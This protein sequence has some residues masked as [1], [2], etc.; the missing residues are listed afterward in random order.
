MSSDI[1]KILED[2]VMVKCPSCDIDLAAPLNYFGKVLC[3][4]CKE[5]FPVNSEDNLE[6][7]INDGAF[8]KGF[9]APLWPT[10]I[11][12]LLAMTGI[13]SS[14]SS[15]D[16]TGL[17]WFMCSLILWPIIGFSIAKNRGIFVKSFREGARNSAI[18]AIIVGGLIWLWF[19]SFIAGGVTN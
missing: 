17:I 5:K 3:P 9:F 7:E 14:N 15:P 16:L 12:V 10:I 2:K 19:L 6:I 13:L 1:S 4:A 8:W 18:A 11:V